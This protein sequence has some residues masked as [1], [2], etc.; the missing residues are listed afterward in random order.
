MFQ[1]KHSSH[2]ITADV[3]I[4]ETAKAAQFFL[5]DGVA[6]TGTS[7]GSPASAS[8]LRQVMDP[9]IEICGLSLVSNPLLPIHQGLIFEWHWVNARTALDSYSVLKADRGCIP[10]SFKREEMVTRGRL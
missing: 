5:A 10:F 6:L 4:A 9:C 1:K 2:S 3:D 7:T 8:E